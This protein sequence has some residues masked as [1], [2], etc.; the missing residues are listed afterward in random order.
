MERL[1]TYDEIYASFRWNIPA[2]YNIAA[3]VCDRHAADP[4]KF[5][6]IGEGADGKTWQMTF[7]DIQRKANQLAN[8]FVCHRPRQGR[9]GH[10]VARPKSVD[11][12]RPRRLLEGRL[13]LGAGV[14]A[15]CRR[16]GR[17]SAQSCRARACS[18]P[19]G[20]TC[21]PL[22]GACAQAVDPVRIYLIDGREPEARVAAGRD[23]AGERCLHQRRYR[24]RRSGVPEFHLRHDRQSERR[25]ASAP[26][27]ARA[28]AGSGIRSRFLP[29][30]G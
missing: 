2:R 26:I 9:P 1:R 12:D 15:I 6:L 29:A 16:S 18:S 11:G 14:A 23:R 19:I 28:F 21:R 10:A 7:R 22:C 17:V 20:Q 30:A 27:D 4:T 25:A 8:L 3:D 13:G 5:A 24:G